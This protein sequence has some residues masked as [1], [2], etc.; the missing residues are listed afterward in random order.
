MPASSASW[1]AAWSKPAI[2]ISINKK[3]QIGQA[4]CRSFASFDLHAGLAQCAEHLIS[5]GGHK[6]A[7][8]LKIDPANIDEFREAFCNV[9]AETFRPTDD[10]LSLSVDAEVLLQDVNWRSV[11]ELDRLG[12][13]GQNNRPPVFAARHVE[14][15]A[16][17]RKIGEGE[18]HLS[19][20]LKQYKTRIKGIAFGRA[21]WAEE[22]EAVTGTIS[23]CFVPKINSY[24]GHETVDLHLVDWMAD[25]GQVRAGSRDA[26]QSVAVQGNSR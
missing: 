15:A 3:D 7:A 6:A 25:D 19:L 17:P 18:R 4:S 23:I 24:R 1:P 20:Q 11:T 26:D 16:P 10:E 12:P 9:V 8:G 22:L 13:F 5:F 14:L 21:D 2:L